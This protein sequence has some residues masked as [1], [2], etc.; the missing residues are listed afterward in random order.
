MGGVCH[1]Q[2]LEGGKMGRAVI[3]GEFGPGAEV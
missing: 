3:N 1:A 2:V